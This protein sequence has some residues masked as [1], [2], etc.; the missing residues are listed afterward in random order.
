M[1]PIFCF[2][3]IYFFPLNAGTENCQNC[4]FRPGLSSL[5]S[6]PVGLLMIHVA[7]ASGLGV[8]RA[9]LYSDLPTVVLRTLGR[10]TFITFEINC[11]SIEM[12]S[13]L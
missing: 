4:S 3:K 6:H 13:I 9:K 1:Y 2:R 10:R 5:R 8:A 12:Y 11:S 7:A